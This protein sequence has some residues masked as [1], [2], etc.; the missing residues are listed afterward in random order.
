MPG[1]TAPSLVD[2]FVTAPE[3]EKPP[4]TGAASPC[5][6]PAPDQFDSAGAAAA[7]EPRPHLNLVGMDASDA[8]DDEDGPWTSHDSTG[9][10][11]PG[12]HE[13]MAAAFEQFYHP[14]GLPGCAVDEAEAGVTPDAM[15][16]AELD[17]ELAARDAALAALEAVRDPL[18]TGPRGSPRSGCADHPDRAAVLGDR[19][20]AG[21]GC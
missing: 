8:S 5:C 6:A 1:R 15:S 13:Q 12:L 2:G 14:G 9:Q 11:G 4:K 3:R 21:Q 17:V 10:V 18:W 20:G 7:E 19:D 16:D